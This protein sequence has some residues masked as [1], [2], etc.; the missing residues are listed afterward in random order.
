[1][2][3]DLP[4]INKE[5]IRVGNK[6]L[7]LEQIEELRKTKKW[8]RYFNTLRLRDAKG[9]IKPFPRET[10]PNGLSEEDYKRHI[11]EILLSDADPGNPASVFKNL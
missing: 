11:D 3:K 8:Q 1:M 2:S 5:R 7:T 10:G 6:L 9:N 4:K